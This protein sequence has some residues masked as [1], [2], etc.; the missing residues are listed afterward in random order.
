[1]L[2]YCFGCLGVVLLLLLA[3][4]ARQVPP[5]PG[6]AAAPPRP[7]VTQTAVALHAAEALQN[8][9]QASL[10]QGGQYSANCVRLG[11]QQSPMAGACWSNLAQSYGES[12]RAFAAPGP[13][14]PPAVAEDMA[15]GRAA[16]ARFFAL[17]GS[18]ASACA[19]L[20]AGHLQECDR[21]QLFALMQ[22][23]K[24]EANTAF[25]AGIQRLRG[26]PIAAGDQ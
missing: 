9:W 2:R 10:G 7:V 26:R 3:A 4:C 17:A 18:W 14:F 16:A 1:M 15:K 5:T 25:R 21:P 12:A 6:V 23:E 20:P 13:R 22:R 24:T 8:R 19:A 11:L